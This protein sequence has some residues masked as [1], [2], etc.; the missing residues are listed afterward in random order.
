N[1]DDNNTPDDAACQAH[2][3]PDDFKIDD[4]IGPMGD[5]ANWPQEL[6]PTAVVSTTYLRLQENDTAEAA[7]DEIMAPIIGD[8]LGSEGLMGVSFARSRSCEVTRTLS[9]WETEEA[10]MNFVLGEA[11]LNA[12]QRVGEVSRGGSIT[13]HWPASDFETLNW[14]SIIPELV[15]H[16]GPVY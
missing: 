13:D 16:D 4:A 9:L 8:L 10:M 7:F 1:N 11:H 15:N 6:P 14:E 12:I 5:P 3:L 2:I